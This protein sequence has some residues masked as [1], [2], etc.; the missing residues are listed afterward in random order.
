[1]ASPQVVLI[2]GASTGFGRLF[3]ETLARHGHIVF[4][5]MRDPAVRNAANANELRALAGKENLELNVLEMDVTDEVS[6]DRAVHDC[7]GRAGRIDALINN[8]GYA[9]TGLTEATTVNQAQQIMNT[10]FFGAV[11]VD[12]AVL[13]FLRKQRGGLLVHVSSGA[14]RVVVPGCA[15]YCATK[16]AL[17]VLAESYHYELAGQGIDSVILE[18]G[19]YQTAIFGSMVTAADHARSETYGSAA[20]IPDKVMALL[21]ATTADAQEVAETLLAIVETPA[22][23]RQLRYRVSPADLGVEAIN[24][25]CAQTQERMLNAFGLT[26]ETTFS[27]QTAASAD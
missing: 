23:Q 22:G 1:M 11:R 12:R 5:T 4:A 2:T 20:Q 8:A 26:A 7:I 27:Q 14:G 6:V 18:P 10:N 13:P 21:S 17:E 3:A 16:F 24:S 9:L 25:V 15:H 19:A